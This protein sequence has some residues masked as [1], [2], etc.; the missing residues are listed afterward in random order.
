MF[1]VRFMVITESNE[2]AI[3]AEIKPKVGTKEVVAEQSCEVT[4]A[5]T[6]I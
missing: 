6:E 4:V 2:Y 3:W 5:S 1:L